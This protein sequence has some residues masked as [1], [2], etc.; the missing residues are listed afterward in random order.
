MEERPVSSHG[1]HKIAQARRFEA[2]GE[3]LTIREWAARARVS[4]CT[5][6]RR[7]ENRLRAGWSVEDALLKPPLHR[8]NRARQLKGPAR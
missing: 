6:R 8:G 2:G 5:F 7:L 1:H 3:S 4:P